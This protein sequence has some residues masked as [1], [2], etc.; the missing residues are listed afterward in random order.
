MVTLVAVAVTALGAAGAYSYGQDY[1]LHRGFAS[2]V[3]LPRA[4]TG[5]LLSVRF[6]SRALHRRSDY[7]VY[8]PPR[9]SAAQR[10]PVYYLLHGMPGQPRVFVTI[11]NMDVR[12]D[13]LMSLGRARPMILVYPD[14]RIG[15]SVLSDS[16]WANTPSGQFESDVVEV[17]HNVDQHFATLPDRRDRVI[18]GF[19]AGAYGA[20]NVALHH[21]R[22][23][24]NVQSWSGYFTQTRTG[25]FAHASR[26]TLQDNSPLHYVSGLRRALHQHPLR[27]DLFVGRDDSSSSQ[28]LPMVR[29]LIAR[30]VHVRYRVYPG[31]HDWSVWYPRLNQMLELASWSARHPPARP[32]AAHRIHGTAL[33]L[34]GNPLVMPRRR[35]SRIFFPAPVTRP[36]P[37]RAEARL[38]A[39]GRSAARS[40]AGAG[41]HHRSSRSELRLLAALL[42]ALVSAALINIGFVLQHRG[43][44]RARA[45]GRASLIDGCRNRHWLGGQ[46]LGWLGFAGQIVSVALAP[47]TLVQA[48]AAGGLAISVPFAARVFGH[49]VERRQL[50]AI[51][52][53][54][55]SLASLP[56]GFGGHHGHLQ[57]GVLI[58]AAMIASFAAT[59]SALIGRTTARAVAAGVFYGVA[60]AA[61][62]ADTQALRAHGGGALVSGWTVIAAVS[63]LGGFLA[64]QAALRDEN[65]IRPLSL[66]NAFTAV[67]ALGL[68]IGAFGEALGTSPAA[69]LGHAV[70]IAIVLC[71]VAPLAQ[72]Q[73]RLAHAGDSPPE[74]EAESAAAGRSP[75]A[76]VA[77]ARPVRSWRRSV[78]GLLGGGGAVL[79]AL[80]AC[81]TGIGLL[82]SLRGLHWFTIG[83]AIP[84]ALPLLQLAGFDGQPLVRV[85]A[86]WLPAGLVLGIA[87]IRIGPPRRMLAGGLLAVTLLLLASDASFALARNLRFQHILVSRTPQLGAWIEALVLAAGC[88][89]PVALRSSPRRSSTDRARHRSQTPLSPAQLP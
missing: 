38:A 42:L 43:H 45:G 7:L 44:A 78:R 49:R 2:L 79:A 72:A 27:T 66:M 67:T 85:I 16:E 8:L 81:L 40:G 20:I 17:M 68:G 88:A 1:N 64:F 56:V 11:A 18:G 23:F 60:D 26:A 28:Q 32:F 61:I 12:L 63:T 84:D 10:Y 33:A 9:Y 4:G 3:Q 51:G 55:L 29:A 82:Y 69:S 73:Q 47:L 22:D 83:P 35:T 39:G 59:G 24:A 6:Y 65:A 75:R 71:C 15:A 48:F 76:A 21:L 25:V 30:G 52:L 19:S 74:T 86:A 54:T 34:P 57:G 87:L 41:A 31:G 70:A 50:V 46:V 77:P 62:K 58:G 37:V 89:L 53:I 14:G 5:R 80:I 13:N 36:E